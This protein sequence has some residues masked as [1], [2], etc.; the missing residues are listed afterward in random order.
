MQSILISLKQLERWWCMFVIYG[1]KTFFASLA[2]NTV[3][4]FTYW[5]DL[6]LYLWPCKFLSNHNIEHWKL[7][8]TMLVYDFDTTNLSKKNM[9]L[10]PMCN[11]CQPRHCLRQFVFGAVLITLV[12]LRT[13]FELLI[14][15][16]WV[17]R[18]RWICFCGS[19]LWYFGQGVVIV[20]IIT[21]HL[22]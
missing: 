16:S 14:P 4:Y 1:L 2:Y 19:M 3:H 6:K 20:L 15:S 9:E 22:F 10:R 11:P 18:C 21:S 13:T 8:L 17:Y 5:F 12:T 7:S